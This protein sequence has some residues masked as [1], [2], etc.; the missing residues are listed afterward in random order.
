MKKYP[1]TR[2]VEIHWVDST[3]TSGWNVKPGACMR[4]VSVGHLLKKTKKRISICQNRSR[5]GDGD[6]MEIP[7]V[8]VT[9]FRR[10]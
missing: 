6:I 4:C 1:K 10:L 9:K 7:R 8:A 3:S 2:P 5:H